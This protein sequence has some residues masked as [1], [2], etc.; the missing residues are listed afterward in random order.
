MARLNKISM[1]DRSC[2]CVTGV[3]EAPAQLAGEQ[4]GF[5]V[6]SRAAAWSRIRRDH[7][8]VEAIDT[9]PKREQVL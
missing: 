6:V 8:H 1:S 5:L 9:K 7:V 2:C 3:A 4:Q